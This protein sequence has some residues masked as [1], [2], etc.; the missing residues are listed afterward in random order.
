[1]APENIATAKASAE[2]MNL[3][4]KEAIIARGLANDGDISIADAREI[5]DYLV[6]NYAKRWYELRGQKDDD[7]SIGYGWAE[8]KSKWSNTVA[9]N[10]N[11][12]RVWGN[13]YKLGF[14]AYDKNRLTNYAGDK[15]TS[16]KSAG[17][18]LSEVMKD[19]VATGELNNPD[20][21]EVHGTTNTGLDQIINVILLLKR[22]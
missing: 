13:I 20:Y 16:F 9:L 5:N 17:Y 19:D 18:Y 8:S 4:I 7:N 21:Q 22:L 6:E 11:A 1:M 2:A 12:V 15:S 3:L 14:R 10:S